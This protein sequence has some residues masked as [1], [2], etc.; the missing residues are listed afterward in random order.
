VDSAV[1]ALV[2]VIVEV[3]EDSGADEAVVLLADEIDNEAAVVVIDEMAPRVETEDHL[4]VLVATLVATR[5]S[6]TTFLKLVPIN[7]QDS[8]EQLNIY[9]M[10]LFNLKLGSSKSNSFAT[11]LSFLNS[12]IR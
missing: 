3:A 4:V 1:E 6:L 12:E 8:T 2:A 5:E 10:W 7:E 9:E 11:I